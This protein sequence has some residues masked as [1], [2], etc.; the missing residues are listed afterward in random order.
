MNRPPDERVLFIKTYSTF[1]RIKFTD[2]LLIQA[3]GDYVKIWTEEKAYLSHTPI[4][5][6][7][8]MLANSN[9]IRVHRSFIVNINKISRV[10]VNKVEINDYKIPVSKSYRHQLLKRIVVI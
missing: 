2:V 7:E 10:T 1:Q 5:R 8:D 9:F 3:F 4:G 6:I